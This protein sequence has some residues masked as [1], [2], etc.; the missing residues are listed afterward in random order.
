MGVGKSIPHSPLHTQQDGSMAESAKDVTS[1]RPQT[2]AERGGVG[3]GWGGL[4]S[5]G[6]LLLPDADWGG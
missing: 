4:S 3:W 2:A 6:A 1:Y 5:R